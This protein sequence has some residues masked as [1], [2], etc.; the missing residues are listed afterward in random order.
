MLV[1]EQK[2]GKSIED[3][4]DDILESMRMLE[5]QAVE[6]ETLIRD[7]LPLG[8]QIIIALSIVGLLAIHYGGFL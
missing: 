1:L 4:V 7:R 3:I 6:Q 8:F 2:L 5:I